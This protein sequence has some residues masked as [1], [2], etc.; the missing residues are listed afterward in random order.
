MKRK[1]IALALGILS[2][3]SGNLLA[4]TYDN[5]IV[6]YLSS[7][8]DALEECTSYNTNGP[9]PGACGQNAGQFH[10][11]YTVVCNPNAAAFQ[12]GLKNYIAIKQDN[13]WSG[14][15]CP[16]L[17][18]NY[19]HF[20]YPITQCNSDQSF[21]GPN[22]TDCVSKT[23]EQKA[24]AA[25]KMLGKKSSCPIG[26]PC[27][28]ATGNKFEAQIDFSGGNGIPSFVR[29]YNSLNFSTVGL[30]VGWTH[31][32]SKKI[33]FDQA[34][35]KITVTREDGSSEVFSLTGEVWVGDADSTLA[36]ETPDI[37]TAIIKRRDGGIETYSL[38]S[39]YLQSET[40]SIGRTTTLTYSGQNLTKITGPY[41]HAIGVV[42][43]STSPVKIL[44]ITLPDGK[45]VS[46]TQN[47][48]QNLTLAAYPNSS[49]RDYL[50]ENASLPH[51][52]TGINDELNNRYATYGYD[53]NGNAILT[54]H[55]GQTQRFQFSYDNAATTTV[56]LA[57]TPYFTATFSDNLGVKRLMSRTWLDTAGGSLAQQWDSN[58]RILSRTDELNRTTS[59][60]WDALNRLSSTTDP[61]GRTSSITYLGNLGLPASITTPSVAPGQSKVVSVQYDASNRP[62]Q[63]SEAGFKPDGT[64]IS[65]STSLAWTS[66]GQVASVTDARGNTTTFAYFPVSSLGRSG[67][68]SSITNPL[69]QTNQFTS[70]D[71]A[72]RLLSETF[73]NGLIRDYTY[74]NVGNIKTI[75]DK[76]IVDL[77][78]LTRRTTTFT[79]NA[80]SLLLTQTLPNG[81]VLTYG[82]DS[83]QRLTSVKDNQNNKVVYG[84][85][86]KNNRTLEEVRNGSDNL[87][88]VVNNTFDARNRISA[89]NTAGS[90]TGIAYDLASQ[91]TSIT[92][93]NSHSTGFSYD[94]VGRLTQQVNAL[95]GVTLSGYSINDEVT[96]VTAPNSAN[97]TYTVD[98]FGNRLT[99][100]SPDRGT[101]TYGYDANGNVTSRTD[102]RGITATI[103]YDALNRVTSISYPQPGEDVTFTYDSCQA[104]MGKLC[105]VTDSTGSRSFYYDIVGPLL[106]VIWVTNSQS[107][108]THYMWDDAD[109]LMRVTYPSGRTVDYTRG[110]TRRITAVSSSGQNIVTNRTYRAD[111]LL[112]GQTYANGLVDSRTYD[113]QG[114]LE[115]WST[116]T[117][118]SRIYGNDANGN[119]S[120]INGSNFAYDW[121]DRLTTAPL[122]TFAYDPNGNRTQ[123]ASGIYGYGIATNRMAT[124]PAG[125]VTIDAAG[126]TTAIG[127]KGYTYNQGGRLVTASDNGTQ[128]G[129]YAYAFDGHRVTKTV[130][131]VTTLY[132]Y[133]IDGTLIAET[134]TSGNTLKEYVWDDEGRPLAMISGGVTTFLHPD[135]LGSPRF[136]TDS[137]KNI[138]WQWYEH[139]FGTGPPVG[140]V[141]VN[142]RYPGQYFDAETGLHQNWNRTYDPASGRYLESDPVGLFGGIN[143]YGYADNNPLVVSDQKGLFLDTFIDIGFVGYDIYRLAKD[144]LFGGCGNLRENL[145]ALGA[146]S[147]GVFLPGV[148][149]LGAATRAVNAV[150]KK[151]V[152]SVLFETTIPKIGVG[153]RPEHFKAANRAMLDAIEKDKDFA[154]LLREAGVT[155]PTNIRQSPSG[156]TWHHSADRPGVMQLVPYDQHKWGSSY[157]SVLHPKGKGGFSNWGSGY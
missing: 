75:A 148:T 10:D 106:D 11:V 134:D 153:T 37:F 67:Q 98:D 79:Y 154:N 105:G 100:I 103:A 114:R 77:T 145:T 86:N 12:T 43:S 32:F 83:A 13:A 91:I 65:R 150:E 35:R 102:A 69:G 84:Y 22:P 157:Q 115:T 1:T 137:N 130:S 7:S 61:S 120:F 88:R 122:Q 136:G 110:T 62:T 143:T 74:D 85:D 108:H 52:L 99:E 73:S 28:A 51:A 138:V 50:Y 109:L 101:T 131:G 20:V 25:K 107:Y 97:T 133:A 144:N 41:G 58:N 71:N 121:L 44:R 26:N 6:Q 48:A 117:I 152:Y 146:D 95:N 113:W 90:I 47:A 42:W 132:H 36:L 151:R 89:I 119:I 5:H 54:E 78:L 81:L 142:L 140:S 49:N 55:T 149:G 31:S 135:H 128:V 46:Y 15:T 127:T 92:D 59:F 3:V 2:A 82:Y 156:W 123:D 111:G 14:A 39:G 87:V 53:A 17:G 60:S 29:Y 125:A 118:D 66:D 141:T 21:V 19:Y 68:L 129:Q 126:N 94:L 45:L 76:E 80:A 93:P 24:I 96:G 64:P 40:D 57:G 33:A 4:G 38:S 16:P 18:V 30:G 23:L 155:I 56:S 72:G 34:N 124:S 27:D 70:Y 139:P 63:I 9:V 112:A 147:V 8:D 104:G 116:G